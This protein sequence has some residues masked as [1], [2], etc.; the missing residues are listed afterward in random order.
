[1][2][3]AAEEWRLGVV[4]KMARTCRA[5]YHEG[6]KLLLEER[7]YLGSM[8]NITSFC[9]FML[10]D[11]AVRFS[12]FRNWLHINLNLL[13]N[14][15]MAPVQEPVLTPFINVIRRCENLT[16]LH[17]TVLEPILGAGIELCSALASLPSLQDLAVGAV[18]VYDS[19]PQLATMMR[20]IR[21]PLV[22]V[23]LCLPYVDHGVLS[24]YR[25]EADP[26]WL[27]ANLSTTLQ[28][29]SWDGR[30][31]IGSTH[32]YPH[33]KL[34]HTRVGQPLIRP[35]IASFPNLS[36]FRFVTRP[37]PDLGLFEL[38]TASSDI[39]SNTEENGS[40]WNEYRE[41]NRKDQLLYG[42]W[43]GLDTLITNSLV[44]Y[45]LGLTCHVRR[46]HLLVHGD[47]RP[48]KTIATIR[49]VLNDTRPCCLRLSFFIG[50]VVIIRHLMK[51]PGPGFRSIEALEL[52]LNVQKPAFNM[53][54][55][56]EDIAQV[57]RCVK[58][59]SFRL[60]I[61]CFVS[62]ANIGEGICWIQFW[63]RISNYCCT[64]NALLSLDM[65]TYMQDVMD[66]I[67]T[68]RRMEISWARCSFPESYRMVRVVGV[69]RDRDPMWYDMP[70]EEYA[71]D[72]HATW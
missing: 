25:R 6:S 63:H 37:F 18:D 19:H 28:V 61:S 72:W 10:A 43:A 60:E 52:H 20:S 7:V 46:L 64:E 33:V 69:N 21:S 41:R 12:S 66:S 2:R 54:Q 14:P 31:H 23:G 39:W 70:G 62:E 55:F 29:F 68:L 26:I 53:I 1:M 38:S 67:P 45:T 32:I 50:D 44:A 5:L 40:L 9:H 58:V 22:S 4:S 59:S 51:H 71:D 13:G 17:I 42:T 56:L 16:R 49:S 30:L 3:M 15:D 36:I 34:C 65:V 27:F 35:Y 24:G 48:S 11:P 8:D 47:V 57:L